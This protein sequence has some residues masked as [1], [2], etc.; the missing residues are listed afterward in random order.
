MSAIGL[1]LQGQFKFDLHDKSGNLLKSSNFVNN[2]ITNS[3]VFYPY[4]FAFAD[5]FRFLSVGSGDAGNSIRFSNE[6][7]GLEIPIPEYSYIGSRND[8]YSSDTNYAPSACGYK[9]SGNLI[10]LYRQWTLPNNLGGDQGAFQVGGT[11]KEFMVTPGRPYE[12][13]E[14]GTKLCTCNQIEGEGSGRDCSS[15]AEYYEWVSEKTKNLNIAQNR[16]MRI[17]EAH[18]AF[19]RIVPDPV[20]YI[21][22]SVLNVT[23]KL[24]VII[25][26]GINLKTL[27]KPNPSQ[28]D[29]NWNL[30][31]NLIS[32]IT[33]PGIKL[34]NDG[35]LITKVPR[36]PE[37]KTRLQHYNY[38]GIG[39][40][41][42]FENEY[43]ESFVPPYGAP[44]EPSHLFLSE[45]KNDT[46]IVYYL[47][48]D[49]S[50][51]LVS[52]TGGNFTK[53]GDFA[54]WN[55]YVPTTIYSSGNFAYSGN[56]TYKYINSIPNS[57]K[58]LNNTQYWENL[59]YL[60]V[61]SGFTSG[62]KPFKN[63]IESAINGSYGYWY[64]NK[65][66]YNIRRNSGT[67]ANTGDITLS[68][69]MAK[70]HFES[71]DQDFPTFGLKYIANNPNSGTRTG[72]VFY[73]FDFRNYN[74]DLDFYARSLVAAYKD[75]S[76][77]TEDERDD[78]NL[79][80]FFDVI[81]SGTGKSFFPEIIT[82][83]KDY[84]GDYGVTGAF[85]SGT[86]NQD[87][88]YLNY[89]SFGK[90]PIFTNYLTWSVPCPP[91]VSGCA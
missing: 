53:T 38:T 7:T 62:L 64:D 55:I 71:V 13:G 60:K 78:K 49:N 2:F 72:Q 41:Y 86:T 35:Q 26:S 70:R 77:G 89:I 45:N 56:F 90:Y 80:P 43:G 11:F 21:S 73:T 8:F 82:G 39:R 12:T 24:S 48:E 85:I 68:V 37:S 17:C 15:I 50:Q 25:D 27:S 66:E 75:V 29:G 69:G 91:S 74:L 32:N 58:P 16:K 88:Y 79:I 31:L 30:K 87:Y 59:N 36:A 46:N 14:N 83:R 9:L 40:N 57:G 5:C 54:P 10:E 44:L 42:N 4:H 63:N 65:N 76:Y 22:G 1:S 51:F 6:T 34:I 52:P 84:G 3:G 61:V 19:A 33:Q 23:Y 20:D 18:K 67:S 28:P 47:S 81:F